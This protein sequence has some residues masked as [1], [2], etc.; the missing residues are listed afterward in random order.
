M[1]KS[2]SIKLTL[3]DWMK[4]LPKR[5]TPTYSLPYQY[6]IKHAGPEEFQV[7]GGGQEI[8]ADGLRLTDGFL[9]EC[10]FI[11]QPDRSPFV[12]DSQIPDFIRQRIVTQVADEWYR[13]AA[14]INDSQTPVMGLEVITNEPRAV[15]FFQDLLDR[16]GMNGR[17]VV[18]K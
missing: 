4:S 3:T 8:W 2:K 14:V 5:V 6:Q 12:A 17:V 1:K 7:A 9:L 18:L 15:P 11:D 16:Y 10:K 13:Y